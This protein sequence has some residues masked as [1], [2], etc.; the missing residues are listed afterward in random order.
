V[1]VF[2][3][4]W[5]KFDVD[6]IKNSLFVVGELSGECF[7]CHK[8]GVSIGEKTCPQCKKEFKFIAFRRRADFS[9]IE[10]FRKMYPK[11]V[12]IDFDD[13]KKAIGKSSARK[14]LDI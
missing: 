9:V 6:D 2:L 7:S 12:F 14:L 1:K 11:E 5:Y 4:A 10:R 3:R 13:F 8:V